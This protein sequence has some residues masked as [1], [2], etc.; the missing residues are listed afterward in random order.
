MDSIKKKE[1]QLQE[2]LSLTIKLNSPIMFDQP[3]ENMNTSVKKKNRKKIDWEN[4]VYF[5]FVYIFIDGFS[6][7]IHF[8]IFGC[9][10]KHVRMLSKGNIPPHMAHIRTESLGFPFIIRHEIVR[11]SKP[12][13]L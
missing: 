10:G 11:H 5:I 3:N 6:F 1:L 7:I 13:H 2:P 8:L 9:M 4:I 12:G